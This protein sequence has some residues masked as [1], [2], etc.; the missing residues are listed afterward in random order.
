MKEA[1]VHTEDAAIANLATSEVL[2]PSFGSLDVPAPLIPFVIPT[3][4]TERHGF[5]AGGMSLGIKT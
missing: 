3:P 1:L 5:S 2:Q 4:R